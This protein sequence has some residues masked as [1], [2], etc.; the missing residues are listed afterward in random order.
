MSSPNTILREGTWFTS[1]RLAGTALSSIISVLLARVLAPTDYGF[2][3]MATAF[4]GAAALI[5][6]CGLGPAIVQQRDLN[7]TQL[8]SCFW[9]SLIWSA[10]LYG[11]IFASAPLV[12]L[13]FG[14]GRLVPLVRVI[15]LNL[16]IGS[17][18]VVP[19]NLLM[20][21]M[22]FKK[23]SLTEF[24]GIVVQGGAAYLLAIRGFGVWSLVVGAL[25][26]SVTSVLCLF[27]AFPWRPAGG[28]RL[29]Q[30][31]EML[32]FGANL[33]GSR[34][35]WYSYSNADNV[36]VAKCLDAQALGLYSMAYDL[37]TRPLQKV[38]ILINQLA[39]PIFSQRQDEIQA[40]KQ[41]FLQATRYIGMLAM[42]AMAGAILVAPELV[43]T[44]L[45][46][47]WSAMTTPF[48]LLCGVSVLQALAAIIPPL[49]NS[50]GKAHLNLRYSL[51]CFGV[52]PLSLLVGVRY[53]LN[54][55]ALTWLIVYPFLFCYLLRIGL[56][57]IGLSIEEYLRALLP[58]VAVTSVMILAVAAFR[59]A[60][61]GYLDSPSILVGSVLI[62]VVAYSG[63]LVLTSDEIRS[64]S[65]RVLAALRP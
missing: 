14:E 9:L 27:A 22:N 59:S 12:A 17:V 63:V 4:T 21:T 1:V 7:Q 43:D 62:G 46:K 8:D 29:R 51:V 55:V 41:Y 30:I 45:A 31:R 65:L 33:T 15:G 16:V 64:G 25:I 34:V 47:K 36:I 5:N 23:R 3:A 32:N 6:E 61:V 40:T 13:F 53:G 56:R 48:R 44:L 54:A 50:R 18:G 38:T 37:A 11:V 39:F 28:L 19:D 58:T 60:A 2:F 57:E 35:L 20:R 49:L 52:M 24:I 10:A 42:P 26:G